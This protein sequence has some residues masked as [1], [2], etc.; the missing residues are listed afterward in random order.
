MAALT[1][2]L[3]RRAA[4]DLGALPVLKTTNGKTMPKYMI[5]GSYTAEGL[6]GLARDKASGRKAAVSSAMK[7][8]NAKVESFHFSFGCE[9]VVLIVDAPD[10][11]AVAAMSI[12][13]G[14]TG[15]VRLKTTPLLTVEEVDKAL[16]LPSKY[17]GPGG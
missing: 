9:D 7:S 11:V 1:I 10:N 6:K 15:L 12:Q 2:R 13:V 17:R 4:N 16:A 3:L 8:L 14:L 5:Q